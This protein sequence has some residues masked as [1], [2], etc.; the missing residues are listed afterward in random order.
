MA[1]LYPTS[2]RREEALRAD[3]FGN[4][5]FGLRPLTNPRYSYTKVNFREPSARHRR[6]AP[7]SDNCR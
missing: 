2:R 7:R 4:F 3:V 1:L 6:F 5:V